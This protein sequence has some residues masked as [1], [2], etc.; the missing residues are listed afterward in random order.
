MVRVLLPALLA[1]AVLAPGAGG[2]PRVAATFPL[3]GVQALGLGAFP[4]QNALF[5]TDDQ[6]GDL[7]R[8]DAASGAVTAR[9][10]VGSAA[11]ALAVD[12]RRGRVVV[13]SEA[14]CCTSGITE[15]TG[16]LSIVD[17]RTGAL[18]SQFDPAPDPDFGSSRAS[19]FQLLA[20][21]AR[22]R[23]YVSFWNDFGNGLGV[24]DL[25]TNAYVPIPG[26]Q[27]LRADSGMAFNRVTN[28]LYVPEVAENRVVVVDGETLTSSTL[29]LAPTRSSSPLDV[30][31]NE[32]ENKLYL[33]MLHVPGQAEMAILILDL[34]TGRHRFVGRD[35]LEPLAF[36]RRTNRLFA[37]VQVGERGAVVDGRTD[38]L[39]SVRLGRAGFGAVGL[40]ASSDNAYFVS[41]DETVVVNGRTRCTQVVRTGIPER[42][43]LVMDLVAVDEARGRVYVS[44]DDQARRITVFR[45]GTV[46]CPV[47]V[48]RLAGRTLA[49]ARR[50]LRAVGL[51]VGT[52][53]YRRS[54]AVR[55]GRV[56][57]QSPRAGLTRPKGTKV[58]LVVSRGAG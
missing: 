36:N 47:R 38:A 16:R 12:D 23:V 27:D 43:G 19:R 54:G 15:G 4:S 56:I 44:N 26:G 34:D 6:S 13:G 7:L 22:G 51:R 29:R 11:Y 49:A 39:R 53:R 31:V 35:D 42:G 30:A 57:S 8:L 40:R 25:A 20:D 21:E 17:A 52:V 1:L 18:L 24:V 55:R 37:G 41:Q 45:D 10:R 3:P 33:T 14:G 32:V 5:V 46:V 58:G 2:A 28:R 50:A 48:P 9:T